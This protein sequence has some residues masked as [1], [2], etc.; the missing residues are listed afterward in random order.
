[1]YVRREGSTE[2]TARLRTP[3]ATRQANSRFVLLFPETRKQNVAWEMTRN[4]VTAR[5]VGN[6]ISTI[7][8]VVTTCGSMDAFSKEVH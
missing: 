7:R 5:R 3:M 2:D 1:M 4:G 6:L 8:A